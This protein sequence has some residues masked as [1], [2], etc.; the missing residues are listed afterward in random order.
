M[1]SLGFKLSSP[2]YCVE[3]K[4]VLLI[5]TW[6]NPVHWNVVS[7]KINEIERPS[8]TSLLPMLE[9]LGFEVDSVVIVLDGLVD[10]SSGDRFAEGMCGECGKEAYEKAGRKVKDYPSLLEEVR[11]ISQNILRCLF[12]KAGLESEEP[13][14]LVAPSVGRPGGNWE[15]QGDARDFIG[16][17]LIELGNLI[18]EKTY[19]RIVLDLTHGINFMPAELM[20]LAR[21]LASL[22]LASHPEVDEVAVEAYNSDPY[23]RGTS[24]LNLNLVYRETFRNIQ[25]PPSLGRLLTPKGEPPEDVRVFNDRTGK[26]RGWVRDLLSSLYY[27]LPLALLE[28]YDK[29]DAAKDLEDS[30][31]RAYELWKGNTEVKGWRVSRRVAIN[32]ESVYAFLLSRAISLYLRGKVEVPADLDL[33][34]E[35]SEAIYG[36]VGEIHK[37]IIAQELSELQR[38]PVKW[39]LGE[40]RPNRRVMIAHAGLQEGLIELEGDEEIRVKY[41]RDIREILKE[42]GLRLF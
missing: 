37:V 14:I 2:I 31:K 39:K 6:G 15:F 4:D 30:V 13:H 20:Y 21:M 1:D 22:S 23:S 12:E 19:R 34:R 26:L 9:W 16:V 42:A 24:P 41:R 28:L 33:L 32:Y 18:L 35:I 29:E 27:P 11:G 3:G 5:S 7:Y 17:V 25:F 38:N 8:C 40:K 36:K 10:R